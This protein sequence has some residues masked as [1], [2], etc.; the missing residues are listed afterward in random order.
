MNFLELIQFIQEANALVAQLE[1]DGTLAKLLA[2]EQ[3]I[4]MELNANPTVIALEAQIKAFFAKQ[5]PVSPI[6]TPHKA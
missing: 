6:V 5:T 1:K 2:A 4:Q 3:A